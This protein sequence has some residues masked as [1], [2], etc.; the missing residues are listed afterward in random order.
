MSSNSPGDT[1]RSGRSETVFLS[2]HHL[3]KLPPAGEDSRELLR[4]GVRER[5]RLGPHGLGEFGEDLGIESI[6]FG[7]LVSRSS[8]VPAPSGVDHGH[9]DPCG[10][11]SRGKRAL[12]AAAGFDDHEG[13]ARI[14]EPAKELV[15]ALLAIGDDKG[16]FTRQKGNL[17]TSFGNVDAHFD[18]WII[19]GLSVLIK[20]E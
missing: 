17:Q 7:K 1:L 19:H 18:A 20:E 14:L 13:R 4:F 3:N 9:R 10:G 16:L 12:E 5:P 2:G 11:Q 8:E 6:S 15:K